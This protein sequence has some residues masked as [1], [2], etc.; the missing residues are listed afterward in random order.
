MINSTITAATDHLRFLVTLMQVN[1]KAGRSLVEARRDICGVW[2]T[3]LM[4]EARRDEA[5]RP[6]KRFGD[7]KLWVGEAAVERRARCNPQKSSMVPAKNR[8]TSPAMPRTSRATI[9]PTR[10]SR[11]LAGLPSRVASCTCVMPGAATGLPISLTM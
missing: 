4:T 11:R 2:H 9:S 3:P 1:G 7:R 5:A 6:S 8:S 10:H